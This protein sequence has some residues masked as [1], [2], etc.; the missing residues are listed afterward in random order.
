MSRAQVTGPLGPHVCILQQLLVLCGRAHA[1]LLS[2]P[3]S[4]GGS[5]PA[6]LGGT[7]LSVFEV[8]LVSQHNEGEV[9]RVPGAGLDEELIS[10][11]VQGF[12]GVGGGHVEHQHAAVCASVEGHTKGLEPLLPSR[13]PDLQETEWHFLGEGLGKQLGGAIPEEPVTLQT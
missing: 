11:A 12:E 4:Q 10:P 7:Y 8:N 2:C 13:V 9:L 5:P 3:Q 1:P 6:A